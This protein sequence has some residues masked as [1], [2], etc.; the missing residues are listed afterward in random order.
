VNGYAVIMAGGSGTRLWPMSR[1]GRPKQLLP[2]CPSGRSLLAETVARLEG[3]FEA[4]RIFIIALADHLPP[5][6]EALPRLPREN[7]IGEP[8]GRDTANAIGLA[9]SILARKD[10]EATMG[11]FTAD[12]LIE[13]VD[14]F[15]AALQAAYEQIDR[16][17]H[18]LATFGIKPTWAHTGLGY[19]HRGSLLAQGQA[20]RPAVYRVR[21]FKEKPKPR[22]ARR[23]LASGEYY[24]NSGMFVWK[25]AT[26]LEQLGRHLPENAEK[27]RRLGQCYG[28]DDWAETAGEVYP[29]LKKISID[30]AVMEKASDVMVVELPC[31]WVDVGS[32]TQLENVTGTDESGNALL[33]GEMVMLDCKKNV[34][35]CEDEDHL[36]AAVGVEDLIVVHTARATLVCPK[37]QAQRIKDLVS[38]I[39]QQKADRFT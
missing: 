2:L 25:V 10:P 5:I 38:L 24:W 34:L 23:Y 36:L 13:P 35:V 18:Y 16:Q 9:A 14:A 11:V 6:A 32:W 12:H 33:G 30:Y 19:I 15:Q 4:E 7:L 22:T 28:Q 37:D 27:L 8:C 1:K 3:L 26:I 17:G 39:E 20:E 31:R 21:A 29:T